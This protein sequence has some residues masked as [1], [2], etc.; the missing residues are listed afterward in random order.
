MPGNTDCQ[1][2]DSALDSVSKP[3]PDDF[4]FAACKIT[5]LPWQAQ[6]LNNC[7]SS[8]RSLILPFRSHIVRLN[9]GRELPCSIIMQYCIAT[10]HFL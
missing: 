10:F 5:D 8:P 3:I 6:A 2:V 4:I 1:S 9:S 7:P